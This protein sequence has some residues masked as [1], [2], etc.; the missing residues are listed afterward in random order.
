MEVLRWS[1]WVHDIEID[2]IS[3]RLHFAGVGKLQKSLQATRAVFRSGSIIAMGKQH[4]DS[5]ARDPLS[6]LELITA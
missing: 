5:T 4:H 3:I 1:G 2:V 6:Y